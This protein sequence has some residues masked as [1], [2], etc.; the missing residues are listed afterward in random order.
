MRCVVY[1]KRK[2]SY[3]WL[4]VYIIRGRQLNAD[5]DASLHNLQDWNRIREEQR[6]LIAQSLYKNGDTSL[7]SVL[8]LHW[9]LSKINIKYIASCL[10]SGLISSNFKGY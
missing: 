7:N 6:K 10:Q 4:F 2:K 5:M 9:Y 1:Y 3:Y 8:L